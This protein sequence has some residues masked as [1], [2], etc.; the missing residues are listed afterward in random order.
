MLIADAL[1][2]LEN[3]GMNFLNL[4]HDSIKLQV[5]FLVFS[6]PRNNLE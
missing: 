5:L 3:F 1:F 4:E 2:S 6:H